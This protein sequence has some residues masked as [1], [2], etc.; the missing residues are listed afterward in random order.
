VAAAALEISYLDPVIP[1]KKGYL[2]RPRHI[3]LKVREKGSGIGPSLLHSMMSHENA[4]FSMMGLES[5][6][7]HLKL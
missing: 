2:S 7:C 6:T 3:G 4:P 5:S 1:D